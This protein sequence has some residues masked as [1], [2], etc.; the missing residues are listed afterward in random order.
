MR[1]KR[2]TLRDVLLVLQIAICAVLVTSSMVAVRGLACS[3][4][5][6]FGFEPQN[7]MVADTGLGMAGYSGDRESAMQRRMIDSMKTIPG[8]QSAASIN[9]KRHRRSIWRRELMERL[10]REGHRT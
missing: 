4:H 1:G 6:N 7:V 3:M 9:W 2:V 8:V 5:S 10:Y